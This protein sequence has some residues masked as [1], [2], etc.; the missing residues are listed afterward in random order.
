MD[1]RLV[2]VRRALR[3][4][5]IAI[6]C[7]AA[8]GCFLGDDDSPPPPDAVAP[9]PPPGHPPGDGAGTIAGLVV[10]SRSGSALAG[11]TVSAGGVVATTDSAGRYVLAS[12]AA[13]D[14]MAVTVSK[15]GYA[16]TQVRPR[17]DAGATVLGLVVRLT[18]VALRQSFDASQGVTA[19]MRQSSAR[20]ELPAAGL[21]RSIGGGPAGGTVTIE[22]TPL[23]PGQDPANLPGDYRWA[24]GAADS[25][26]FESF[27]A[28]DVALRDAA[29]RSL[30]LAPGRRALL[31]I[32][33]STRA[34]GVPSTLPLYAFDRASGLWSAQGEARLGGSAP[35]RYFEAMVAHFSIWGVGMPVDTLTVRGCVQDTSARRVADAVVVGLGLDHSLQTSAVTAA[36][37]TFSLQVQREGETEIVAALDPRRSAARVVGELDADTT[38]DGCLVLSSGA[39]AATFSRQPQDAVASPGAYAMF[40]AEAQGSPPLRYQW[41]RNGKPIAG[42]TAPVLVVDPVAVADS[43]AQYRVVAVNPTGGKTSRAAT[44]TVHQVV[45]PPTIVTAPR[46]RT[47]F[48]GHRAGFRVVAHAGGR[49][50]TYQWSRNGQPIGRAVQPSY[51]TPPAT[52]ADQGSTYDVVVGVAGTSLR[53]ASRAATLKVTVPGK[54]VVLRAPVSTRVVVGSTATFDVLASSPSPLGYLWLRDGKPIP[55]AVHASYTTPPTTLADNQSGYSVVVRVVGT[56]LV[57]ATV[58]AVLSVIPPFGP[59]AD[60]PHDVLVLA[61]Q[62]AGF[63]A[64]VSGSP[65]FTY[66]WLRNDTPIPG[67]TASSYEIPSTTAA[68]DA[69][70]F[71]YRVTNANATQTSGAA[72]LTVLSPTSGAGLY[73]ADFA[74]PEIA[75]RKLLFADGG[76]PLSTQAL[77]MI[78]SF[79]PDAAAKAEAA[80]TIQAEVIALNEGTVQASMVSG[81]HQRYRIYFDRSGVLKRLDLQSSGTL[82]Q[83]VR[84]STLTA[85]QVCAKGGIRAEPRVDGSDLA[86][87]SRGWAFFR[88]PGPDGQCGTADDGAWAVRMTMSETDAPL[89]I[90]QPLAAVRDDQGALTGLLVRVGRAVRRLDADLAAP[91]TLFTQS[92]SDIATLGTA[93]GAAAPGVWLYGSASALY[94]YRL[95]SAAGVLPTALASLTNGETIASLLGGGSGAE[96]WL[97]LRGNSSTRILRV[98]DDLTVRQTAALRYAVSSFGVTTGHVIVKSVAPRRER[99]VVAVAKADGAET[100]LDQEQS[101]YEILDVAVSGDNVY[102]SWI[103]FIDRDV[104]EGISV[105]RPDGGNGGSVAGSV[106]IGTVAPPVLRVTS[107]FPQVHAL[108]TAGT[109][110]LD[111]LAGQSVTLI[112]GPTRAQLFDYGAFRLER[113][114]FAGLGATVDPPSLPMQFG[115]AGLFRYHYV[116]ND[117]YAFTSDKAGL[118]K[119]AY[120]PLP[121]CP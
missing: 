46:N 104:A 36:D 49:S 116:T 31:R 26:V 1:E 118:R 5:C 107:G 91:V 113:C 39:V 93:F 8:G 75:A 87:A 58:P 50:L 34:A 7:L 96:A 20:A 99:R 2:G 115:G 51:T 79:H 52:E 112:E 37:G 68:D 69:A 90:G 88:A 74:G 54:P 25:G 40:R 114:G 106:L 72:A 27:G 97:A 28:V 10:D 33:V 14:R 83:A 84:M 23:N 55:G 6:L 64:S 78:N 35:N 92:S 77:V 111:Y 95:D 43:G 17:V 9:T 102:R 44:L 85:S 32:P 63:A 11:A 3:F 30:D 120:F 71:S 41:Q 62:P 56:S 24:A 108:Y 19:S 13:G 61:G 105:S 101:D 59:W 42:A 103:Q 98:T 15:A 82:P 4:G 29:G 16:A 57:S 22:L 67:A 45:T 80:G 81:L 18:P 38:L 110:F 21:V 119:V 76:A 73:L 65:P 60:P 70:R 12:V 53:V 47:V 94:G 48:L 66:Q 109:S 86:N 117:L 121:T 89:S 100:T